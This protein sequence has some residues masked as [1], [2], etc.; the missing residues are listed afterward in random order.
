MVSFRVFSE[1]AI[2]FPLEPPRQCGLARPERHAYNSGGST[3]LFLSLR[4]SAQGLPP[5]APGERDRQGPLD[6]GVDEDWAKE[7]RDEDRP[8]PSDGIVKKSREE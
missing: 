6:I 5:L 3:G 7:I 8:R 2:S 1:I 4:S